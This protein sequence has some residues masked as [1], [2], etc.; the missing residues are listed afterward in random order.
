M[1]AVGAGGRRGLSGED[2]GASR[3]LEGIRLGEGDG[4]IFRDAWDGP[5]GLR[6]GGGRRQI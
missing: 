3:L 6:P 4:M 5:A 2:G 1:R